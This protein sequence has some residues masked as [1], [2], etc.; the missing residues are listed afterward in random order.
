VLIKYWTEEDAEHLNN[1][2]SSFEIDDNESEG[3]STLQTLKLDQVK[4]NISSMGMKKS[5]CEILSR[6]LLT[7][8]YLLTEDVQIVLNSV[9]CRTEFTRHLIL[10]V[11]PTISP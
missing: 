5:Y 6:L 9:E 3:G 4:L 7:K 11:P 8:R 10:Y 2:Q 1:I